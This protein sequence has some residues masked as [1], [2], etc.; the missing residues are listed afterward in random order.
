MLREAARSSML[1]LGFA[2][3]R[4]A[5]DSSILALL[6]RLKPVKTRFDLLRIGGAGDG[7]Y[8]VPDDLE[9]I[10]ACFSPGVDNTA[11][12][13]EEMVARRIPCFL[14]DASVGSAPFQHELIDFEPMFLDASDG[15]G[16][17][18][19]KTWVESKTDASDHDFLLQMD[20]EGH[21]WSVL[22]DATPE[23]LSRFRILVLE[24]H[25]MDRVFDSAFLM[26]IDSCLKKLA[27]IFHVVHCHPNNAGPLL[28]HGGISIPTLLE[29][30][31]L[32]RDRADGLGPV[33]EIPHAL[34][35]ANLAR[36]PDLVLP[37][38][39]RG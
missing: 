13:E 32:R 22:L 29:V 20:I 7:G 18:T 35:Q 8:L 26:I 15:V 10:S 3:G 16:T 33:V 12:F 34:D 1:R 39:I 11:S 28:S 14:A 6:S 27:K 19:L 25:H 21:E 23:L 17:I 5:S 38:C 2:M 24:L 37:P 30:T 31:L 36:L 9:G 4:K